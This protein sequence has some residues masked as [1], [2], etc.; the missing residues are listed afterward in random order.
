VNVN[1]R[2]FLGLSAAALTGAVLLDGCSSGET[3]QTAVLLRSSA[4]LPPRF[5]LPLPIPPVKRPISTNGGTDVY[6]ITQKYAEAEIL[7][8]RRTRIMGY[9]GIFPGPT[10]ATRSG[11]T[12]VVRHVNELDV[13][14]VVHLHGGHTPST[15]DG[16]PTDLVLPAAGTGEPS[17]Q[18]GMGMMDMMGDVTRGVREYTYPQRQPAATLWY[19]DHRMAFTGPQVWR[20]LA[21]FHLIRDDIE[22]ALPLPGPERDV[23][24]MITDRAFEADGAFSYPSLDP[25][26]AGRPGVRDS[27]MSGV[28]GDVILVNGVP[29]PVLEVDA[30]R[31]RLRLLNAS[32]ARRYRLTLDPPPRTG[33]SFVQIGSD[34][35]LLGT[36]RPQQAIVSAP[37]ERFDVLVDF[38]GYAVGTEV[39]LRNTYG[40]GGTGDVMRFV[41]ARRAADDSAIPPKLVDVEPLTPPP[42]ARVRQWRFRR[43]TVDGQPGWVIND[44]AFD[45]MRMLADPP[46]GEI[47]I[48]RFETDLHHPVHVHLSPFQVLNRQGKPPG[49]LDH[50][51]KDTIDLRPAEYAEVAVRFDDYAGKY[52]LHCHNL[53]HEDM[54]MMAAFSTA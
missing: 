54:A 40:S 11:R 33:P 24:L 17:L 9:D 6:E 32:N 20:G 27:Y 35:G 13:P 14:T 53:E 10:L 1:R 45:P 36:P 37:A 3:G 48:W 34:A 19:H 7:P 8:G 15:S 12:T 44:A 18:H 41:V 52:L 21:G 4:V 23:P 47:E 2:Q 26:L 38:S 5:R 25:T 49:G 28:L 22:E 51:W 29:W 31:Y 39:T 43:G 46:L 16:F 50:G 30:A 42:G